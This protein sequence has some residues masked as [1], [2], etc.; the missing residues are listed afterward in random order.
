M[1]LAGGA[2][3]LV[4]A[5]LLGCSAHR[6]TARVFDGHTV[7]GPY[8]EPEA[9]A[10]FA[11]GVYREA[12]GDTAGAL[13]SYRRAQASDS[14]SP[15]IAVRIASLTCAADLD[16]ALS[17][18]DTSGIGR[19]YAPAWL[20]RGRCLHRHGQ[21]KEALTAVR[22]AVMLEPD[23]PDAN[24]LAAELLRQQHATQ[25]ASAWL[26]AWLLADPDAAARRASIEA[27]A[28]KL[29]DSAL[30][31]LARSSEGYAL[32]QAPGEASDAAAPSPLER[33][34]RAS[35]SDPALALAEARRVLGANPRDADALVIALSAAHRLGDEQAFA[36]LLRASMTTSLPGSD[37]APLVIELLRQRAGNDAADAWAEANRARRA[38]P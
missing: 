35:A 21:G 3:V 7:V 23:A 19:N 10:A 18:L 22:R 2:L 9:Y 24:L 32:E 13:R 27:E 15:A 4:G 33:A 16:A 25:A 6:T 1:R 30:L 14:D 17:E 38:P 29:G 12:H 8:I 34:R 31:E 36:T 28:E 20:E 37:L 26:F 5:A 11:D